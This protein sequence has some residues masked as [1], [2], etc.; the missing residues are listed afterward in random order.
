METSGFVRDV[1]RLI[2]INIY[3]SRVFLSTFNLQCYKTQKDKILAL[4]EGK[5]CFATDYSSL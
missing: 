1:N 3:P 5:I 4:K 2:L